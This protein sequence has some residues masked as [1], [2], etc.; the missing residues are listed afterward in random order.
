MEVQRIL[1]TRRGL[2]RLAGS[3]A[4]LKIGCGCSGAG[5]EGETGVLDATRSAPTRRPAVQQYVVTVADHWNS[6]RAWL[7]AYDRAGAGWKP[8]FSE[9]IP[10]LLGKKGMAWGLGTWPIRPAE[11]E[12]FK[13]EG[14]WRSPAG[15][16]KIGK[17]YGYPAKLPQGANYPYRQV[18]KWDAWIDDVDN[19]LYN[20]HVVVDPSKGVP[21]WFE[22]GKMRHGDFAYHWL[23]EIRHNS[24]PPK[25]GYGSAIFF[26]TRRGENRT[27]SGCTTMTRKNLE[28]ILKWLRAGKNPH[29]VLLP[30]AKYPEYQKRYGLPPAPASR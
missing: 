21:T 8:L 27:T 16:F 14:D 2:L 29:Y 1:L 15:C 22:K 7:Q 6:N 13:R 9:P 20:Q 19:P 12:T 28:H 30:R 26:H 18:T 10:V 4:L 23:L 5:A 25:A 24:D 11:G 3:L 17:V